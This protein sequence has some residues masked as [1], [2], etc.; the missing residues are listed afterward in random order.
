ML[1]ATKFLESRIDIGN[2]LGRLRGRLESKG[3]Q[4]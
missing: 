1:V 2:D 3:N 4:G